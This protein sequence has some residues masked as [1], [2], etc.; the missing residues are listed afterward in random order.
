LERRYPAVE[1]LGAV[2]FSTSRGSRKGYKH[3]K[4][5]HHIQEYEKKV[6]TVMINSSSSINQTLNTSPL[7]EMMR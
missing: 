6:Q 5:F 7:S 1:K 3:V 4:D 2:C